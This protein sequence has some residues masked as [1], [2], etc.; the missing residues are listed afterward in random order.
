MRTTVRRRFAEFF[1]SRGWHVR[2]RLFGGVEWSFADKHNWARRGVL[3]AH[4]GFVIIA[5]GTTLYWA[6]GFSGE[7]ARAHRTD[8]RRSPQTQAVVRLDNFAYN[9]A[10]IMTKSG[11]VYQPIDYVSHV[12]VTGSDGIPKAMTRARQ[13]SDRRRR[14][15]LLSSQLRLRHEVS[16]Y[17]RRPSRPERFRA[18]RF[19]EGDTFEIP[20]AQRS[21]TYERFVPDRRQAERLARRPT[22]G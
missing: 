19:L 1:A 7:L 14:H 17:A 18:A 6:R 12:T 10:P 4:A 22:R 11:M 8:G 5:A 9:I 3:I 15:A 21:V 13:P 2:E 16:R 20:G